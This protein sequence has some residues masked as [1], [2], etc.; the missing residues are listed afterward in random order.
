[1]S[2]RV[3]VIDG[4]ITPNHIRAGRGSSMG[5]IQVAVEVALGLQTV[6]GWQG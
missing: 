3:G 6:V 1:M 2:I 5:R 4:F